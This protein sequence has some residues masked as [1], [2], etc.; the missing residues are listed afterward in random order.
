MG[1]AKV[2]LTGRISNDPKLF[3][4][5]DGSKK[6]LLFNVATNTKAKDYER[7]DFH[8]CIMWGDE[9]VTKIS[10]WLLKGRL[11]EITGELR[12]YEERDENGKFVSKSTEILVSTIEFLDRKPEGVETPEEKPA[13]VAGQNQMLQMMQQMMAQMMKGQ[14]GED[15]AF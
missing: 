7:A 1:A 8:S 11:V 4:N 9:R 3:T 5:D 2:F 15:Q 10:P 14:A 12:N 6:R 13:D